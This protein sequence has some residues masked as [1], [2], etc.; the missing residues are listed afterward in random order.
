MA[1]SPPAAACV[2]RLGERLP[3]VIVTTSGGCAA[4][5]ATVLGRHRVRE[6]SEILHP[7]ALTPVL[8]DGRR[9]RVALQDSCQLRNGLGVWREPRE[10]LRAVAD[11]VEVPNAAGCCGA[12]GTYSLLRPSDSHRVLE[13]KLDAIEVAGVDYV[14]A[15]NPVCLRQLKR[16]L[17]KRRSR[18]RA[19]HLVEFLAGKPNSR[20]EA[21]TQPQH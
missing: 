14:V 4:H 1:I 2:E 9:A 5:L 19:I 20:H 11:Y 7:L 3:G 15:L 6:L 13:P 12:A 8:V 16:G 18:V 10:I 17:R 21:E